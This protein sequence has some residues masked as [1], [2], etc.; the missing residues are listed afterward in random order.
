MRAICPRTTRRALPESEEPLKLGKYADLAVVLFGTFC[1]IALGVLFYIRTE[2]STALAVVSGLEGLILTLQFQLLVDKR[3][4]SERE[5]IQARMIYCVERIKWLPGW[6][7]DASAKLVAIDEKY[8]GTPADVEA[9]RLLEDALNRLRGLER[10][11][12]EIEFDDIALVLERTDNARNSLF[13]TSV[14]SIDLT[15][16]NT[17][18]GQRYWQAHLSALKRGIKIIRVFIYD[19]WTIELDALAS[20]Q[21]KAGVNVYKV[22]RN[23]LQPVD[24]RRD[25]IIWDN[26]CAYETRLV[27][28]GSIAINFFMVDPF[29]IKN[30]YFKAERIL[31]AADQYVASL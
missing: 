20:K 18:H 14:Q 3:K 17:S 19:E 29:E 8:R 15:W 9:R 16:W 23:S 31:Q 1:S 12:I 28:D 13:A 30:L 6:L 22:E 25:L 5:T 24:L 27:G 26:E 2:T 11:Q 21:T 4:T 10:G 7:S